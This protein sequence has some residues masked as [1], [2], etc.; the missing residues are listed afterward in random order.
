MTR[1]RARALAVSALA[2]ALVAAACSSWDTGTEPGNGAELACLDTIEAFARAAERCG[3][4]YKATYDALLQRNANGDCKNVRTIRD[5]A[6]LRKTCLPFTKTQSCDDR[7]NG[8]IDPSC[9]E[10]LQRAL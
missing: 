9:A 7:R 8:V 1:L 2:F 3:D 6:A 5:E 4:D 10:Q